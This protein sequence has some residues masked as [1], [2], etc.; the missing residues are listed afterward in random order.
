LLVSA[1]EGTRVDHDTV[2]EILEEAEE[3]NDPYVSGS[4]FQPP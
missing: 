4:M 3:N 2:E 1:I